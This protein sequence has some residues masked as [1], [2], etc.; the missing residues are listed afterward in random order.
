MGHLLVTA[1]VVELI[2]LEDAITHLR[3]DDDLIELPEADLIASWILAARLHVESRLSIALVEQT[4]RLTMD[5]FPTGP[6]ILPRPPLKSVTS[7][8][9]IDSNGDEQALDSADYVVDY[10]SRPGRIGPVQDTNWPVA[11]RQIASVKI[12]YVAGLDQDDDG[13]ADLLADLRA[14]MLLLVGDFYR[15]REAQVGESL[16]T[17]RAV[18]ALLNTHYRYWDGSGT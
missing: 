10:E 6:I 8:V 13:N 17:N 5:G 2:E 14:A 12:T 15:N 1:P 16:N 11:A 7:V 9:Y 18:D 3:G 4:W